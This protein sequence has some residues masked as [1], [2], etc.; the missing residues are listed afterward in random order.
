MASLGS[1]FAYDRQ[2]A[3]YVT[4]SKNWAVLDFIVCLE[5]VVAE[6]PKRMTIEAS[7]DQAEVQCKA[8][9]A[10]LPRSSSEPDADDIRS[11]VMECGFRLGEGSADMGCGAA[12]GKGAQVSFDVE[13]ADVPSGSGQYT[14]SEVERAA[15]VDGVRARL[16]DPVSA[17][18]GGAVAMKDPDSF[19]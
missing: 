12:A 7:L 10:K 2:D 3:G 8:T 11:M 4:S 17:I 15:I 13:P 9:A 5:G 16:K 14:L 18:F 19:V 1:G 6:T